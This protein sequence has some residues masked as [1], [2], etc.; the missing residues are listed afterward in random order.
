[1]RRCINPTLLDLKNEPLVGE[2]RRLADGSYALLLSDCHGDP[3]CNCYR[4]T[5][6]G[7]VFALQLDMIDRRDELYLRSEIVARSIEDYKLWFKNRG[8]DPVEHIEAILLDVR[9]RTLV[10]TEE[11]INLVQAWVVQLRYDTDFM[12]N[13]V[14]DGL[15]AMREE[16]HILIE[17]T[18]NL[19]R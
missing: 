17:T 9:K 7:Y 16:L 6:D 4:L 3:E 1:M 8:C 18:I 15:D 13:E 5:R 10:V 11:N 19:L 14:Y 2:T 12:D